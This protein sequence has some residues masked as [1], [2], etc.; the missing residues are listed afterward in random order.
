MLYKILDVKWS[1]I[2]HKVR[3]PGVISPLNII[4]DNKKGGFGGISMSEVGE[5]ISLLNFNVLMLLYEK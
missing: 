2:V 3:N 4:M 1:Q 5:I